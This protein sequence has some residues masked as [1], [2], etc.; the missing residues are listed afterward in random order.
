M[1]GFH[2]IAQLALSVHAFQLE[3][4]EAEVRLEIVGLGDCPGKG[5]LKSEGEVAIA[6]HCH[7]PASFSGTGHVLSVSVFIY[8]RYL[9]LL[10]CVLFSDLKKS[11]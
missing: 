8:C 5:K 6:H 7:W 11:P 3:W 9:P 2:A 1:E 4:M 10:R